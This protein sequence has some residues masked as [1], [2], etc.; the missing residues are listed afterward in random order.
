MAITKLGFA[1]AAVVMVAGFSAAPANAS[2][3]V[4]VG[5]CDEGGTCG[6]KQRTEPRNAA[7]RLVPNDLF[8]GAT[9]S[10]VCKTVGDPRASSGRSSDVWYQLSN[11]A[12][13]NSVYMNILRVEGVP[14]C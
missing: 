7:P 11:G 5:T 6:V 9:V 13:V 12:Y 8:D 2:T 4:I 3:A 14:T 10:V 1:A